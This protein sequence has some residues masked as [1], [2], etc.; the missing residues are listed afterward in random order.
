M[1]SFLSKIQELW[2]STQKTKFVLIG[3]DSAGKTTL[4][5]KLKLNENVSTIPTIGF[6]VEEVTYRNMSMTMWDIGGQTKIRQLWSHYYD[7]L[8]GIIFMIDSNDSSRMEEV[9]REL[10]YLNSE[11]RLRGVPILFYAN[12]QDLPR[13]MLVHEIREKAKIHNIKD[14]NWYIQG[15]SALR[16]DGVYEGMDWLYTEI[17]EKR[18]R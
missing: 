9:Q 5:Y 1:G 3:L 18:K 14:R 15:C 2:S 6:N 17:K 4:L 11:K 7:N 12:K 13:A 10:L 16:G 8:D